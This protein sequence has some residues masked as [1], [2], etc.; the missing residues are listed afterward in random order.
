MSLQAVE[1]LRTVVTIENLESFNRHVREARRTDD[2]V[3]YTG[4]S[5][6]RS[7]VAAL[8]RLEEL[9]ARSLARWGD[10]DHG[11]I[12]I[13]NRLFEVMGAPHTNRRANRSRG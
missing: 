9:G 7:V 3:L 10:V 6:S 11:G 5:P 2:A 1:P 4:G 13:A 12:R 8:R